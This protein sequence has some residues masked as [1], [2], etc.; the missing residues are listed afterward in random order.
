MFPDSNDLPSLVGE[1][2]VCVFVTILVAFKFPVPPLAVC[3]MPCAVLGASVPEAAFDEDGDVRSRECDVDL[4]AAV[5]REQEVA[6]GTQARTLG[7][8][9]GV[10]P[11][12]QR[13]YVRASTSF[14][15]VRL[16][17][18]FVQVPYRASDLAQAS[19]R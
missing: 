19:K 13:R 16:Q 8:P 15:K 18:R 11:L 6:R 7:V 17:E 14:A 10:P 4:A 12:V 3:G 1:K 2:P 5:P 9:A